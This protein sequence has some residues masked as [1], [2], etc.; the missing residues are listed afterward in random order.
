MLQVAALITV[1]PS[2][3]IVVFNRRVVKCGHRAKAADCISTRQLIAS[4]PGS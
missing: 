2:I 3:V 1:L 4:V